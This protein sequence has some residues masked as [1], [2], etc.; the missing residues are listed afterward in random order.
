MIEIVGNIF[1]RF[2]EKIPWILLSATFVG[3]GLRKCNVNLQRQYKWIEKNSRIF[4]HFQT[5]RKPTHLQ[6]D[7]APPRAVKEGFSTPGKMLWCDLDASSDFLCP[8]WFSIKEYRKVSKQ[9]RR[10]YLEKV[11]DI[12]RG[13]FFIHIY[14][15]PHIYHLFWLNYCKHY[16]SQKSS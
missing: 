11:R 4:M 16:Q 5:A 8:P 6:I 1:P 14:L 15:M 9:N 12:P 3:G 10:L 2:I 7:A 13:P